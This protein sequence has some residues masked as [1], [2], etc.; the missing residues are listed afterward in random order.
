MLKSLMLGSVAFVIAMP[1]FAEELLFAGRVQ[2]IVL[3]PVGGVPLENGKTRVCISTAGACETTYMKVEQ[4]FLGAPMET[5]TVN[6]AFGLW[7][8]KGFRVP[9]GV[10]LVHVNAREG[11]NS[12]A[13]AVMRD[14]R[15]YFRPGKPWVVRG[16]AVS[17][18]EGDGEISL[19]SLLA[20]LRAAKP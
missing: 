1:A 10:I 18:A 12:W 15:L 3:Q 11:V 19:D 7:D 16:V 4:V 17:P 13:P 9:Q 20:R 5:I 2:Q 14:G 8:G 6:S